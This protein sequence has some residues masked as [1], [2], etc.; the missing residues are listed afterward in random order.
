MVAKATA[1]GNTMVALVNPAKTSARNVSF[2]T[3][4]HQRRA[5]IRACQPRLMSVS[6]NY[7][8]QNSVPDAVALNPH[9]ARHKASC[10]KLMGHPEKTIELSR[11]R[12]AS[13]GEP[14]I[15]DSNYLD[16][17]SCRFGQIDR[18]ICAS[19]I[20][21]GVTGSVRTGLKG[22][23]GLRTQAVRCQLPSLSRVHHQF[24]APR[25]PTQ[26]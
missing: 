1:C 20:I 23:P 4:P 16:T 24:G 5:G 19:A 6:Q 21:S 12:G 10:R 15:I 7:V 8:W 2:V 14:H 3:S 26:T 9:G 25:S 11:I 22:S 18:F 17:R 13:Y